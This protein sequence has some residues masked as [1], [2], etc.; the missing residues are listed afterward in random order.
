MIRL[1]KIF[2][3]FTLINAINC[4]NALKQDEF[5]TIFN[6]VTLDGWEGDS[7]YWRVENGN[8]VGEITPQTLLTR[9]N[10]KSGLNLNPEKFQV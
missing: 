3:A 7:T 1:T 10:K 2:L 6:G 4:S 9:N 5:I 8:L